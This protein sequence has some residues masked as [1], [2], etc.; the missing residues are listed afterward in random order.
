[1]AVTLRRRCMQQS[2]R[3]LKNVTEATDGSVD[4]VE[5]EPVEETVSADET[6][7]P[8]DAQAGTEEEWI[9]DFEYELSDK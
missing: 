5:Q 4:P 1:M 8:G 3:D 2:R 9:K 7:Q 6:E